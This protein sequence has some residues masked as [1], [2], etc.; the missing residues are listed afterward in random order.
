[1]GHSRKGSEEGRGS[2][3]DVVYQNLTTFEEIPD[4]KGGLGS[5]AASRRGHRTRS[6]DSFLIP[7]NLNYVANIVVVVVIEI[8][9]KRV[10]TSR[11]P[12]CQTTSAVP[13]RHRLIRYGEYRDRL[14]WDA[15]ESLLA[16]SLS[17]LWAITRPDQPT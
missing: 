14:N 4:S 10:R 17:H 7:W 13:Y 16:A 2:W 3:C 8:V 9:N 5:V 12:V 1:M 6:T 11:L 15:R